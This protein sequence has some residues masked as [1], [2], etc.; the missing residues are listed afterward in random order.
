MKRLSVFAH[1]DPHGW[2]DPFVREYLNALRRVSSIIIFVSTSPV[3]D[4]DMSALERLN[5]QVITR[6]NEGHDFMSWKVGLNAVEDLDTYNEILICND[7]VY[8]PIVPLEPVFRQMNRERCDFWGITENADVN[9]HIQSYFIVFRKRA[10]KSEAF[11]D[12][13]SRVSI[14]KDKQDIIRMYEVG[15]SQALIQA[16]LQVGCYARSGTSLRRLIVERIRSLKKSSLREIP[17]KVFR[18]GVGLFNSKTLNPTLVSWR[19]LLEQHRIPFIKRQLI[20][21][22]PAGNFNFID[23]ERIVKALGRYDT[24]LIRNHLDRVRS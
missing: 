19:E 13:W 7:S 15:L 16:G 21:E 2:V 8:G 14:R 1:F 4:A 6:R 18:K 9:Y 23:M 17:G 24:N 5:I 10:V 22:N 3:S 11:S 20:T 12:F